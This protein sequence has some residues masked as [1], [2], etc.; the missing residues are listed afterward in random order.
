MGVILV[1]PSTA[2]DIFLSR[3]ALSGVL[4]VHGAK[5]EDLGA[6]V[7]FA[8][9]GRFGSVAAAVT[10][11]FEAVLGIDCRR[12]RVTG[13]CGHCGLVGL[14]RRAEGFRYPGSVSA[15]RVAGAYR[16]DSMLEKEL[17]TWRQSQTVDGLN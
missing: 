2:H 4:R 10:F 8:L 12:S 6:D 17:I 5:D 16:S 14:L 11:G 1:V 7:G 3:D 15:S 9:G 13:W